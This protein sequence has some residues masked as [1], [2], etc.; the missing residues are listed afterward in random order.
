MTTEYSGSGDL[1]R[2]MELLWGTQERPSRGPKPSLTVDRIA[3]AGIE[4]ADAEGLAAVS[5]RRVAARLEVGTMSLYRYVPS[6]AELVDVM[7]DKV[8]GEGVTEPDPAVGWRTG[9]AQTARGTW[10]LYH[11]HSWLLQVSASRPLLGPNVLKSLEYSLG[12]VSDIGLSDA[13]MMNVIVL[14]DSYVSG[15]ARNSVDAAQAAQRTG[16][17]DEQFWAAQEP[18]LVKI[19][20]CG[21]Y[22]RM[23][24]LDA[25]VFEEIARTGFE[26]GLQRLLDGVETLVAAKGRS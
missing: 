13:E 7:L 25:G 21:Q 11:R 15:A 17:T 2:T 19:M 24:G 18:Y 23:A 20:S 12:V 16:V 14:V 1:A 22:P 5:M 6:K 9:L 8:Y 3:Q 26:F 10:E 4:L